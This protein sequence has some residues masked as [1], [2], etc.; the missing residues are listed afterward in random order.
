MPVTKAAVW[1]KEILGEI[2]KRAKPID[3]TG[4]FDLKKYLGSS[5]VTCSVRSKDFGEAMRAW[6]KGHREMTAGE[7]I[8]LLG[9]LFRG[10]THH[11]I[12]AGA[13]ILRMY[14]KLKPRVG[15]EHVYG[16]L[17]KTEGWA[18]VDVLCGAAFSAD[19]MLARWGEWEALLNRLAKDGNIQRRRAS[20]VLLILP[21]RES[22]DPRILRMAFGNLDLLKREKEILITKAVS[23]LLREMTKKH[24]AKVAA[25]LDKNEDSLPKIALRETR[26]K[27]LHGVKTPRKRK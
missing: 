13:S 19:E 26:N 11:D 3:S 7:Y 22:A 24:S 25:Y 10:G 12:I 18:E 21:V 1:R 4:F 17:G 9:E 20:L 15:P 8:D 27:L 23:W 16:W 6:R 14:P 5:K 2:K